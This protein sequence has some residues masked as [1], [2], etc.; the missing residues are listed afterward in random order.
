MKEGDPA[1]DFELADQDGKRVRLSSFKDKKNV[2]LCFYPK[3]HLFAC[4]SKKV[5]KMAKSVIDSY[6]DITATDSVLFAISVDTVEDQKKFVTE[7]NIPYSHLSD[8]EKNA[9]KEYAGLN[10]VGLAKRSTFII[11][12]KGVIRK[13]F[14]D[15]DVENHGREIA[16]F[17]KEL[18]T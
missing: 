4:P 9:C 3:N 8:T 1:F 7:Y 13:I 5:F 14:R 17:L 18:K 12:K 2:V 11:D 10:I 6:S 15:V 16:E